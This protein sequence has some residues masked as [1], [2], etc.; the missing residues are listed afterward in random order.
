MS[1]VRF[2][3]G[4][5]A[6]SGSSARVLVDVVPR[7]GVATRAVS[8]PAGPAGPQGDPAFGN[9]DGGSFSSIP[10]PGVS[11]DGGSF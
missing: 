9:L 1:P 8:G 7:Q 3:G 4:S 2:E 11:F 6:L 5:E 10:A